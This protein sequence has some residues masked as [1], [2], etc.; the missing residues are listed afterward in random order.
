MSWGLVAN[1]LAGRTE[2]E[3]VAGFSQMKLMNARAPEKSE[4]WVNDSITKLT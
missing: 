1:L 3:E 4:E 2:G